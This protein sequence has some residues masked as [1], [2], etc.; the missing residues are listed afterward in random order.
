MQT[1]TIEDEDLKVKPGVS[2]AACLP[3]DVPFVAVFPPQYVFHLCFSSVICT[4]FFVYFPHEF[5]LPV[6]AILSSPSSFV[7]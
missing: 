4:F 6:A 7:R 3:V 1:T 2:L 5:V